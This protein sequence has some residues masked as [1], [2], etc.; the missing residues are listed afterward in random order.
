VYQRA[1]V[2]HRLS[3]ARE[4]LEGYK[5]AAEKGY[6]IAMRGIGILLSENPELAKAETGTPD[7]WR[8]KAAKAGDD[9]S[10]PWL[11]VEAVINEDGSDFATTAFSIL[12]TMGYNN[13]AEASL[14]LSNWIAERGK[15]KV[16]AE[17]ALFFAILGRELARRQANQPDFV[18]QRLRRMAP[19]LVRDRLKLVDPARAT[20]IWRQAIAWHAGQ[21]G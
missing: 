12:K 10:L 1:R 15:D 20:E 8:L 9:A 4:A 17:R 18:D 2:Q 3:K 11:A 19:Q 5:V 14:N 21:G 7:E 6:A 16:A 13:A